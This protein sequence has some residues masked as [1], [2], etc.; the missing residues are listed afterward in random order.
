MPTR[1]WGR[2][3]LGSERAVGPAQVGGAA[4]VEDAAVGRGHPVPTG[5]VVGG[6]GNHRCDQ[7]QA[8]GRA[9]EGRRAVAEDPTVGRTKR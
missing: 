9:L 6:Q 1:S 3:R 2:S 8:A 7:G 4:V 5:G